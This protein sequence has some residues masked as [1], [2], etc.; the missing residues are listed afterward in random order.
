M[1]ELQ[2]ERNI[3]TKLES[4]LP[5]F[6]HYHTEEIL[7]QLDYA[8]RPPEK[9][10]QQIIGYISS[11]VS[12][13]ESINQWDF[14]LT[15]LTKRKFHALTFFIIEECR[16][17]TTE[18]HTKLNKNSL[19][20]PD[21]GERSESP[22]SNNSTI[23]NDQERKTKI[24]YLNKLLTCD[25][26]SLRTEYTN[27]RAQETTET[28]ARISSSNS[29]IA[30]TEVLIAQMKGRFSIWS[31]QYWLS[32]SSLRLKMLNKYV[33]CDHEQSVDEIYFR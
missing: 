28:I 14:L 6:D 23:N 25:T 11:L 13:I 10:K 18:K 21:A 31:S 1:K 32:A 33:H 15:E 3:T 12:Q 30:R 8:G 9:E 24:Y 19:S 22:L 5:H 29:T 2:K 17:M 4:I 26:Q 20:F 16:A 7:N 27:F